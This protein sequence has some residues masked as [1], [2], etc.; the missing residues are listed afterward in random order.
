MA[1][2]RGVPASGTHLHMCRR[3][4]LTRSDYEKFQQQIFDELDEL[5]QAGRERLVASFVEI[6]RRAGIDVV[7][8]ILDKGKSVP[9]VFDAVQKAFAK[10]CFFLKHHTTKDLP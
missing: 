8:E 3:G 9:E 5:E 1:S 7:S 10:R 4:H 2:H 6:G